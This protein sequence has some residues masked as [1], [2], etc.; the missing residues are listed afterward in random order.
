MP[1]YSAETRARAN[2]VNLRDEVTDNREIVST[3]RHRGA[4][5][6][7]MVA[8]ELTSLTDQTKDFFLDDIV[9][10]L[11]QVNWIA[12]RKLGTMI[13]RVHRKFT[14]EEIDYGV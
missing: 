2:L 9:I 12:V 13:D 14:N 7:V 4:G 1:I 10:D 5:I 8:D 3:R 11:E 6:N